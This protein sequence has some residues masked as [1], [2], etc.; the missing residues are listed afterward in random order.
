MDH[1]TGFAPHADKDLCFLSGCKKSTVEKWAKD[2]SWIIGIGGNNTGKPDKIIYAMEVKYTLPFK[3]FKS[4]Y[5][6]RGCYLESHKAGP[7]V[8]VSSHYVYFGDQAIELPKGLK[9]IILKTQGCKCV[10]DVDIKKLE[11]HLNAKNAWGKL[12]K[13]NNPKPQ[14]HTKKYSC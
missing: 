11:N 2:G 9:G 6:S 7:N 4:K 13:P 3:E 14:G 8:L 12:G 10:S 1:D 5:P